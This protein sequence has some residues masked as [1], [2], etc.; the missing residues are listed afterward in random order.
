MTSYTTAL[1]VVSIIGTISVSINIF[2]IWYTINAIKQISSDQIQ[3]NGLI[4][5]LEELQEIV[6]IYV[7][8]LQAVEE[9]EI[10][11]GDETLRELMRH[12]KAVTDAFNEYRDSIVPS[13]ERE[14]KINDDQT[15][16][17]PQ[18]KI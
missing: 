4:D 10:F 2:L 13:P 3:I 15:E 11:Y 17:S 6:G 5:E 8:H 12:G 1:I 16:E 9:L 7:N 18:E 14:E